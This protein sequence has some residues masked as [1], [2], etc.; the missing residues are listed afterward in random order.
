MESLRPTTF[1][2]RRY[3]AVRSF[4][5]S[6]VTQSF[7]VFVSELE[8]LEEKVSSEW[9]AVVNYGHSHGVGWV[10]SRSRP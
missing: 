3:V 2:V 9:L 8:S 6:T 10:P 7:G 4:S 1:G 5:S